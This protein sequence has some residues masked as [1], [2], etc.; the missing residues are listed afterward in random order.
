MTGFENLHQILHNLYAE[1]M[2]LC[3][4]MAGIA[5][6][7]AGLGALFYVATRLWQALSRAEPI[8]VYPLLRPFAIGICIMFFP[9]IV[10]GGLNSILSPLVQGTHSMLQ[11]QTLDMNRW[12]QEK[13]KAEREAYTH[14]GK[15]WLVD[16]EAFDRKL[17]ELGI[18]DAPEMI[19]M[20]LEKALYDVKKTMRE[21]F[22]EVLEWFFHAAALC[23]DAIRTFFLVVLSIL[24]PIAFAI[25][26]WDG[27]QSTLTQWITRYV[28]IYLWLPVSDLFSTI[29][30]KIQ[31]LMM[32]HDVA[33]M[34]DPSFLPDST[35]VVYIIF[36][37]TGIVGYFTIPSVSNWIIQAGG[38]G[39]Y[40][41]NINRMATSAGSALAGGAGAAA[42]NVTGRTV[43]N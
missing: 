7:L 24:G 13:D 2:P 15:A 29:L 3:A 40:G 10:L 37:I 5:K 11:T 20:Y 35:S 18:T 19:G 22:R 17:D 34:S 8:D 9:T 33:Q 25:S 28:S 4:S 30:A 21:W 16:N 42:G 6:G 31:V 14:A 43:G 32:Q 1:M 41:R 26:V 27:F 38:M 23:I 39:N 36:L 12:Q